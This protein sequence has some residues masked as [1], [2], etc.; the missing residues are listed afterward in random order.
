MTSIKSE[1]RGII[2]NQQF[3]KDLTTG[4]IPKHLI[5]FALPI[6]IGNLLT[7]GYGIINTIW[8]GNLL[9][10]EAVGAVAVS[11]PIYLALVALCSGATLATFIMIS[12]AYGSKDY[13]RIQKIVNH[14]W[15]IGI[16]IIAVVTVVGIAF[17][18]NLLQLLG[19]PKDIFPLATGYLRL[20]LLNFGGLYLSC[21]ISAIL[22][23]IGDTT[24]PLFFIILSTA[25][26]AV[27][28]PLLILGVGPIPALSLNGAAIAS[29]IATGTAVIPGFIYTKHKYKKEP[30][31]PT[32]WEFD[33]HTVLEILKIG[34]PSFIQ[35]L[36]VSMGYAFIIAFVNRYGAAATAAFGIASR[37][38][39][40]VAMPAMAV[41]MAVSAMTAQNIGAGKFQRI[42]EIM[43]FGFIINIPV[44]LSIAI[45]CILIPQGIMRIFVRD[46][47]VIQTGAD[48]LK[49]VGPG[50]LFF[51]VIYV[52]N[53]VING[54]G[55]T[56]TTMV[57]SFVSLCLIRIP[58]A[59]FLSQHST[60]GLN[61]IWLAIVISFAVT[62]LN[63]LLY[64][65]F[66]NWKKEALKQSQIKLSS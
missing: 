41:M 3:G 42:K 6:L 33:G 38:D 65:V 46:S 61:G 12:K 31:N 40:L 37:I 23:S 60:L 54:A 20:T 36:L 16:L 28:D 18:K 49:I 13:G 39:S 1:K 58:L 7:T 51:T 22:R 50:Y 35:Q 43:K 64:N 44:I 4:S 48:Y 62:T 55:K 34:L 25:V 47:D 63:S 15:S 57:I 19:T 30:L 21:L 26:N 32:A 56:I 2:L 45:L 27:L 10:K 8:V 59:G 9:G 11:F 24:I 53:G 52:S 17:S 14:S 5:Q 66:G 29:F